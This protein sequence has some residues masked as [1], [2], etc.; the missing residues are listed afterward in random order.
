MSASSSDHPALLARL[1]E[2]A[3][4]VNS[5]EDA[6]LILK[7]VIERVPHELRARHLLRRIQA[8]AYE[9]ETPLSK[10]INAMKVQ[11]LL[12]QATS[13]NEAVNKMQLAEEAL[14]FHPFHVKANELLA[15]AALEASQPSVAA[16]A[17]ETLL[18]RYHNDTRLLH[19]LAQ[20]YLN[21]GDLAEARSVYEELNEIDPDD[22]DA[23]EAFLRLQREVGGPKNQEKKH[24]K[25]TV[26][27]P[28]D[29]LT[30]ETIAEEITDLTDQIGSLKNE[31]REQPEL[32]ATNESQIHDIENR[33]DYLHQASLEAD[34][35]HWKKRHDAMPDDMETL[36]QLAEAQMRGAY[37]AEA[38]DTLAAALDD[39]DWFE[40]GYI[41]STIC[42]ANLVVANSLYEHH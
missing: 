29:D 34:V 15:E 4:G 25:D 3:A 33:L 7:E 6:A 17:Y 9:Q 39:P 21:K 11:A 12:T 28:S 13:A 32:R 38:Y 19:K 5:L 42:L 1:A 40:H 8:E 41:Q 31:A 36:C 18:H 23:Q 2:F 16:F 24:A 10:T 22:L 35:Y 20:I 14:A 30:P 26:T 37:W 27:N